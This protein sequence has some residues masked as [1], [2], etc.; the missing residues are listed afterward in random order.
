MIKLPYFNE[1]KVVVV[2]AGGTG[3]GQS[4]IRTLRPQLDGQIAGRQIGKHFRQHKRGELLY[5][6]GSQLGVGLF[7]TAHPAHAGGDNRPQTVGINCPGLQ[8]GGPQGLITGAQSILREFVGI[9]G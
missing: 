7:P 9:L 4:G 1:F 6:A 5:P 8:I 3:A 2:G